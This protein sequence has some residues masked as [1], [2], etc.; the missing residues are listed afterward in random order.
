MYARADIRISEFS[1]LVSYSSLHSYCC[2]VSDPCDRSPMGSNEKRTSLNFKLKNLV[3]HPYQ[4]FKYEQNPAMISVD[5]V[6]SMN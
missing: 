5:G 3:R 2:S 4:A 1:T 6:S